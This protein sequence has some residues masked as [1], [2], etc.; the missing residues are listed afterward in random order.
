M[1]FW[2]RSSLYFGTTQI[3]KMLYGVSGCLN[4]CFM[5]FV[6][7]Q[8]LEIVLHDFGTICIMMLLV[9]I[10]CRTSQKLIL[11]FASWSYLVG[12]ETTSARS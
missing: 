5:P 2:R 4:I 6:V 11:S 8:S 1:K 12:S 10:L 3:I 9:G 7:E